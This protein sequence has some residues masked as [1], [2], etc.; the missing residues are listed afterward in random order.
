MAVAAIDS[1][2][3]H[4]VFVAELHRLG[5]RNILPRKIRRP[6]QSQD[7]RQGKTCQEYS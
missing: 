7:S 2:V 3:A 6:R 1:V 4:V 5:A